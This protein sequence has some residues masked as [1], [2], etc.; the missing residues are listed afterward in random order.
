VDPDERIPDIT[1]NNNL[2]SA[3]TA[4]PATAPIP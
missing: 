1:R 3:P 4:P 2:W